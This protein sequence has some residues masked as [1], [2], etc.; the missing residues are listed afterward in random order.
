MRHVELFKGDGAV[1]KC[2]FTHRP[3]CKLR[4][5]VEEDLINRGC[6]TVFHY[7]RDEKFKCSKLLGGGKPTVALNAF[8]LLSGNN[9]A[10]LKGFKERKYLRIC[11]SF[12]KIEGA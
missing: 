10:L 6:H 5:K 7:S 1:I 8:G 9:E 12:M 3:W 2:P 4:Y 11:I